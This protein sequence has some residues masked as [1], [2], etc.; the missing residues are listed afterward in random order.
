MRSKN[1]EILNGIRDVCGT[2]FLVGIRL[3]PERFGMV[4]SECLELSQ[5][6]INSS[7]I[8]FLDIS[9]WDVFKLP[10][11]S[12]DQ[13]RTILDYFTALSRKNVRL[14]VA[15]KIATA[16]QVKTVLG[17]G[18]DFVSIGRGGI[19]HHDFPN[20]VMTDP[21]FVPIEL[22]VSRNYLSTEGLSDPFI[23]YMTRWKEFVKGG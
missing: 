12:D 7:L 9:L 23:D 2:D 15:G 5:S 21:D 19:L 17:S 11:E 3:S 20:R 16:K 8:D 13:S 10:N 4:L 18:V 1:F 14:T 22:P 6:L